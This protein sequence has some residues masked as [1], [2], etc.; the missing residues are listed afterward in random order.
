MLEILLEKTPIYEKANCM[1]K[2][3][4]GKGSSENLDLLVFHE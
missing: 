1:W 3:T 4:R 2:V